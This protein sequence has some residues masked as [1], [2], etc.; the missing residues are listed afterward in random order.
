MC[1]SGTLDSCRRFFDH[2]QFAF[3][4]MVCHVFLFLEF[5]FISVSSEMSLSLVL[6]AWNISC[7]HITS[8]VPSVLILFDMM[9]S[10]LLF[11]G[12]YFFVLCCQW[13]VLVFIIGQ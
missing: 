13:H 10:I 12:L 3:S 2:M 4:C 9:R 11:F 8:L 5:V 1:L 7:I 6:R